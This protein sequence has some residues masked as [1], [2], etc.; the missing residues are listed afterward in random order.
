MRAEYEML[1]LSCKTSAEALLCCEVVEAM[2]QLVDKEKYSV[3]LGQLRVVLITRADELEVA[4]G[5]A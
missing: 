1:A 5:G 4:E 3:E 2:A